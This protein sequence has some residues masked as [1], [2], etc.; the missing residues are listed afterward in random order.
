[1]TP[2]GLV[3][4]AHQE[5]RP[6]IIKRGKDV[7][8]LLPY[9]LARMYLDWQGEWHL[10]PLRGIAT[11]PLLLDD[12]TIRSTAGYDRLSG[13]WCENV[14]DLSGLIPDRPT[15]S[16]ATAA[17]RLIRETFK[18]FCFADAETVEDMAAGVAV[19]DLTKPPSRDEFAFLAAL[20]T[21]VCRPSLPLAPG[22]LLRAAPLSG[23][24][25]GKGLLAR[26]I[27]AIAFGRSPHAV[28]A[29]GT[30]EERCR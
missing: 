27:C 5:C 20:L 16:E 21:A 6:Y 29:G 11:A 3:L 17:L 8:V 10:P 26:C 13:M 9:S 18:T 15:E 12:G 25:A 19:V 4:K 14:P 23:A 1:M 30:A 22:V 28:T 7:D 24:G 2:H